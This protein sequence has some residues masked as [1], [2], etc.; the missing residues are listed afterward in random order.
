MMD[1][2]CAPSVMTARYANPTT[3]STQKHLR[4]TGAS[5]ASRTPTGSRSA[6]KPRFERR[7]R[8]AAV[9]PGIG[10]TEYGAWRAQGTA[11]T[12]NQSRLT[13]RIKAL[14]RNAPRVTCSPRIATFVSVSAPQA[15]CRIPPKPTATEMKASSPISPSPLTTIWILR[16]GRHRTHVRRATA[17]TAGLSPSPRALRSTPSLCSTPL[18]STTEGFGLTGRTTCP[19]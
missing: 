18:S 4:V 9:Y 14:V 10:S 2:M 12:A 16:P 6:A 1:A 11:A 8:G 17:S 15:S 3:K 13:H 5:R 7:Y 19:R